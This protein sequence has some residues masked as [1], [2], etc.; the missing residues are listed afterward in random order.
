MGANFQCY[1]LQAAPGAD[2]LPDTIAKVRSIY[3]QAVAAA[4]YDHGHDAYNG[5]IS[6]TS[7]IDVRTGED[8]T[9]P[10]KASAIEYLEDEAVKWGEAIAVRYVDDTGHLR[11]LMGFWAAE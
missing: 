10:S 6:T 11:W 8:S 2:E 7:G 9:F 3:T 1:T 5:T 4:E